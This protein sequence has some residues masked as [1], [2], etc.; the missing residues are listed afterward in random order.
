MTDKEMVS[1]RIANRYALYSAFAGV[2]PVPV[3][4]IAAMVAL[5]VKM[6]SEI[7]KQYGLTLSHDLGKGL[8]SALIGGVLPS[9]LG[10]G[11]VGL[12][13]KRIP[14]VGP[15]LGVF[16]V[17]AFGAATTY[18]IAKVFIQHFESGGTFLDFRPDEVREH[19]R[20]EFEAAAA[21]PI[22]TAA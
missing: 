17:S 9:S 19:F 18:A 5:Q 12:F 16:T 8:V 13:V 2:I 21:S 15:I 10:Y 1:L 4:D 11:G 3:F 22:V 6:L 14:I 7:A 20:A